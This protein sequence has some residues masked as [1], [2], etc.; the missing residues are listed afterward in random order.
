M[1]PFKTGE[2]LGVAVMAQRKRTRLVSMGMQVQSLASLSGLR[3]WC[4]CELL[5]RSQMQLGSVI[6]MAVATAGSCSV[7]LTPSLGTSIC[8][9]C[10][11]KKKKKKKERK[12]K[13]E[14]RELDPACHAIMDV[15]MVSICT[16]NVYL[17]SFVQL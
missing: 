13:K 10:G 14:R 15:L 7:D 17:H 16:Q 5:C 8:C 9:R 6:A 3:I 1:I 2:N 12:R 11:P 4:C